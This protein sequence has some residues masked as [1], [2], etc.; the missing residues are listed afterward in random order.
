M[1][2]LFERGGGDHW[3]CA[4]SCF[5]SFLYPYLSVRGY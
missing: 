5:V 3:D 4:V 2:E 1:E